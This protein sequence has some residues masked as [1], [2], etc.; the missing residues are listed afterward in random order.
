[1]TNSTRGLENSLLD[2]P[3]TEYAQAV[4]DGVIVAG[5]HVRAACKRHLNDLEEAPKRGFFFDTE[6]VNW[7]IEFFQ[8]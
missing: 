8:R 3:V 1:M 2:D 4:V 7:V 5:P 6:R